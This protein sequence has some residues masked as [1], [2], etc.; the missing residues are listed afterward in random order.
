MV[1]DYERQRLKNIERNKQL[2]AQLE[3]DKPLFEPKEIKRPKPS[4]KRKPVEEPDDSPTAKSACTDSANLGSSIEG[5]IR[6][7]SRTAGR[8]PVDYKS[9]K[10]SSSPLPISAKARLRG[11]DPADPMADS[12]RDLNKRQHSAK[13]YGT[14]PGVEVGTWWESREQCS[15]YAIHAPPMGGIHNAAK[16]AY[17]VALSGG[18][19]DDVDWGYAFTYTGSGGRD[20]K[21]TAAKPKNLRTAPQSSDQ[22]FDN[23]FNKSLQVSAQTKNPVRVIRGYKLNSPYAPYEGYRYDG[24]Y[25]VE[26]AWQEVGMEGFLVCKY[27]FKRLP[28]QPPLPVRADD[29][30]LDDASLKNGNPEAVVEDTSP[31]VNETEPKAVA[32]E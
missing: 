25:Q 4:K 19:P 20:L 29:A 17:S 26:K 9:E 21:G 11:I 16:G 6:R 7:S 8:K 18:Y 1:S 30:S 12:A 5:S 23:V 13:V 3:L 14:I 27:T 28:N 22:T 10:N 24:L 2:L 32:E 31:K 15:V